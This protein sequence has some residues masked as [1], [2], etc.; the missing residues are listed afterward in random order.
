MLKI[1]AL[2]VPRI[3]SAHRPYFK[4]DL[5]MLWDCENYYVF[6]QNRAFCSGSKTGSSYGREDCSLEKARSSG[7]LPSALENVFYSQMKLRAKYQFWVRYSL[8]HT[9]LFSITDT[10]FRKE[11]LTKNAF[12]VLRAGRWL[13]P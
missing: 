6:E 7:R 10:S 2:N 1:C 4:I 3:R 8:E 13:W 9:S 5:A 12:Q 11:E